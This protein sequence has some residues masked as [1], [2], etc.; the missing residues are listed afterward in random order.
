[1]LLIREAHKWIKSAR[2][3]RCACQERN[4]ALPAILSTRVPRIMEVSLMRMCQAG[5]IR[6]PNI[7]H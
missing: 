2:V 1:M 5:H 7:V 6:V 3:E 4:G